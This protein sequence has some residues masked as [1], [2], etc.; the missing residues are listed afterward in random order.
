[1]RVTISHKKPKQEVVK[2]VDQN[3]NEMMKGL[4]SGPVQIVD[5]ERNW[6][7][8]VM[9][10]SFKAKAGFFSV[11]IVGFI[12]VNE[13]EVIIDA[14]LP[15]IV[16]KLIPEEKIR[17]SLEGQDPRVYRVAQDSIL[18]HFLH[19]SPD[20]GAEYVRGRQQTE[21][22]VSLAAEIVG[23]KY[24]VTRNN[25]LRECRID[26]TDSPPGRPRGNSG[27]VRVGAPKL[28]CGKNMSCHLMAAGLNRT[29]G[30]IF[31]GNGSLGVDALK[32]SRTIVPGSRSG[33]ISPPH[34]RGRQVRCNDRRLAL[35]QE[36]VSTEE[37]RSVTDDWSA[38]GSA[39][40]VDNVLCQARRKVRPRV[41]GRCGVDPNQSPMQ[42][43][44][45]RLGDYRCI[46]HLSELSPVI[47]YVEAHLLD[48]SQGRLSKGI[49]HA[50]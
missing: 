49:L 12:E 1:M 41:N 42:A 38:D 21:H 25:D 3:V 17:A 13:K 50:E 7:G 24:F 23:R 26:R 6:K 10:F 20:A 4:A 15:G 35:P 47:H 9:N 39:A 33:K 5:M 16:T 32:G 28:G 43:V 18:H 11:P 31:P 45:A 37:K 22:K 27:R 40:V 19:Q 36:F 30:M 14:D 2:I 29:A 34:F 48:R 44:L 46:R 8:D